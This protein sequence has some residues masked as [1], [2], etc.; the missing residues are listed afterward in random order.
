L[1]SCSALLHVYIG[2]RLLLPL[3]LSSSLWRAV[4]VVC[5]SLAKGFGSATIAA[6]A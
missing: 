2:L 5:F 1:F 6:V 4:L 3:T